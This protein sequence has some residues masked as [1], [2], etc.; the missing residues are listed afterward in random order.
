MTNVFRFFCALF[1]IQLLSGATISESA[2]IET[3]EL[4]TPLP[5]RF[6]ASKLHD[7][8]STTIHVWQ[9]LGG[10]RFSVTRNSFQGDF[11]AHLEPVPGEKQFWIMQATDKKY[12]YRYYLLKIEGSNLL[13]FSIDDFSAVLTGRSMGLVAKQVDAFIGKRSLF[14]IAD[15]SSLLS[16]IEKYMKKNIEPNLVFKI[17]DNTE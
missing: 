1:C 14:T 8:N 17:T 11:T 15:R 6:I 10:N 7:D 3:S 13:Q 9:N 2:L 5:S 12:S 4:E 16:F